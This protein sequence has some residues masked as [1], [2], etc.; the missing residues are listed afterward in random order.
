MEFCALSLKTDP[1]QHAL[2]APGKVHCED[3]EMEWTELTGNLFGIDKSTQI[4]ACTKSS[5]N[6]KCLLGKRKLSFTALEFIFQAF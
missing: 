4:Q 1:T 5:L 6:S 2:T 3:T